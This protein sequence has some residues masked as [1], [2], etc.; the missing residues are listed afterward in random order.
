MADLR[1]LDFIWNRATLDSVLEGYFIKEVL[2]AGLR[3]PVRIIPVEEGQPI[4]LGPGTLLGSLGLE[5]APVLKQARAHRIPNVG[6][7]HMGDEEGKQDLGFYADADYVIRN[8]W[9]PAAVASPGPQ[10][11]GVMWAPNGYRA[12]LGPIDPARQL[13]ISHRAMGGFFSGVLTGRHLADEREAM[14]QAVGTS[15]VPCMIMT[16][17]GFGQGLG[18]TAYGAWLCNSRF[19]LVP[20]GNSHETIRLYDALEAGAIPVM[21]RSA[22][23]S[24]PEALGALGEPPFIL[25]DSWKDLARAL[26]PYAK[27]DDPATLLAL[28]EKRAQISRWWTAFK[29]HQQDKVTTLIESA[30]ERSSQP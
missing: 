21:V 7:F 3:R 29:Q 5:M 10:S 24:A 19:A 12:G 27:A 25:L 26:A 22:F 11:L 23:V 8:Y 17:P 30:F 14:V 1:P 6:L 2:L 18:P 20:A 16:T 4:P 13:P 15:P 28:E 9:F